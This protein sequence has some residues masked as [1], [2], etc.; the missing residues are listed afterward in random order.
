ML[1]PMT[2]QQNQDE[3]IKNMKDFLVAHKEYA[4]KLGITEDK[5]LILSLLRE[6]KYTNDFLMALLKEI[7][8]LNELL[9]K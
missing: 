3:I 5:M 8:K 2:E 1:L 7:Q 6:S 9:S 4:E